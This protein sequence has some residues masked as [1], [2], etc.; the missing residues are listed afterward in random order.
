MN[1]KNI[2]IVEGEQ[3]KRFFD[4]FIASVNPSLSR[5]V[6]V[7]VATSKDLD[8]NGTNTQ[9]GV[10]R[11][12]GTLSKQ[13]DDGTYH[14]LG[15]IIDMDYIQ[16]GKVP[17][18]KRTFEQVCNVLDSADFKTE[19]IA[20]ENEGT[21]FSN[22]DFSNPIGVWVM[23]NNSDEGY[24]EVWIERIMSSECTDHYEAVKIF[25]NSFDENH[26]KGHN[27]TKARI[28]TWLATQPKPAQDSCICLNS[29]LN[30]IDINSPF[31]QNFKAWLIATF[32]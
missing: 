7:K 29:N 28:Y 8:S 22:P 19:S 26:F 20:F 5:K 23:P 3:D 16:Q 11:T 6:E 12:L 4:K 24:L 31:Y 10:L 21:F 18:Q 17:I 25:V 32:N 30:L 14:R 15:M 9:Q 1:I 13:L 2:L 27:L